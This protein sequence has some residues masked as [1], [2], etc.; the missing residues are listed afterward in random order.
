MAPRRSLADP[1][2]TRLG[3]ANGAHLLEPRACPLRRR[4]P[5]R[6]ERATAG[7]GKSD[8]CRRPAT[9]SSSR[10]T[11]GGV[12]AFPALG[13]PVLETPTLDA[14]AARGVLFANHWANA[15][16]VR[17][18]AGLPVHGDV[19]APQP[20]GPQRHAARRPVHQ[21]R[22]AGPGDSATT[23]CSS[24]TPTPRSIPAPCRPGDPRL[25][26]YEGILPGFRVVIED[27][28]EQGSPAWGRWLA[29]QG[30]DVPGQS[31]RPVRADG[32]LPRRRRPRVDVGA[33]PVPGRALPDHVRAPGRDR[34]ARTQRR[35][36]LLRPRLVHPAPPAPPQPLGYHDLYAAEAIG[37]FVG[38]AGWRRRRPSTRSAAGASHPRRRRTARTSVS[39]GSCG[40]PTTAPQREV[41]DGLAP[42]FEYLERAGWPTRPW[43]S[44][45][46][47]HGEMGCDHW[48]LEKLGYWDESYHVP[49]I[50]VDPLSRGRRRA[51]ARWSTRSPSRS[52]CC[53]PSAS[54]WGSRSHS[55]P[56]GGRW[57]PSCAGE[58]CAGALARHGALR[59]GASPIRR[60]SCSETV[61]RHPH[62]PLR[63]GRVAW[64]A[65]TSTSSSPPP[66][67][68]PALA[69]RPARPTPGRRDNLL[70]R[71][72]ARRWPRRH[73]GRPRSS[74]SGNAYGRADAQRELPRHRARPRGV[75][76]HLALTAGPARRRAVCDADRRPS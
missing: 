43:S 45:T 39:A 16:P 57:P 28:W 7:I 9:S 59:V 46:S 1:S 10:S 5:R 51:R 11:S 55:R 42:L 68:L 24:A 29:A 12:T 20:L 58:P 73:G 3:G 4:A 69:L 67:P 63:P 6:P 17:A 44:L 70:R 52:T 15:A 27:P 26:T 22:A 66:R 8:A 37:P 38:C 48:L 36:A 47:D 21:R 75:T 23:R 2:G 53:R 71:W 41:D 19:P 30:V 74:S 18:V 61:L 35:E 60:T 33:G 31:A 49:L 64:P 50:V 34:V 76:R 32:G 62:E 72:R 14:L 65:A 40:P 56:T 13:H 54:S 25:L